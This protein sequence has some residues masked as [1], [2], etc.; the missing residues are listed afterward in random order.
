MFANE[1]GISIIFKLIGSI[2]IQETLMLKFQQ[3]AIVIWYRRT[4]Y[5]NRFNSFIDIFELGRCR[6]DLPEIN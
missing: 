1:N 4:V 6:L 3:T 5:P 2:K